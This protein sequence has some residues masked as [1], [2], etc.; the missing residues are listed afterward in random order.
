MAPG[1]HH[2]Y[3][4]GNNRRA[5]F[6][7]ELDRA[8]FLTRLARVIDLHGWN[9]HLFCLLTNHF[10]LLVQ[11]HD[12]SLPN[13]MQRLNL[14]TARSFNRRHGTIGHLFQWPY[15]S[16]H[17][18]RHGHAVHLIRYIAMNPVD[19]GLCRVP[20][21]WPW[22]SYG[23]TVGLRDAPSFV[24]TS[25][26]LGLFAEDETVARGRLREFVAGTRSG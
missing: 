19:A 7:D 23:A 13:G 6:R 11:T 10:H 22:S 25:W 1:F 2:V 15:G 18:T 21:E 5:V 16:V 20:E 26:V 12:E 4:R 14:A 8:D 17:V 3:A 9:C 24:T